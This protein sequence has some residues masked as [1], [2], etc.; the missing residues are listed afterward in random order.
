MMSCGILALQGSFAEHAALLDKC[1]AQ[2]LEVRTVSDL[3]KAD[4]LILPGGESTAIRFLMQEAGLMEAIQKRALA[5]M[6]I[7]GTCA[8]CILLAEK[9]S[10]SAPTLGLMHIAV[11]RNA[12]GAQ[13]ASFSTVASVS[14]VSPD[15]LELVFI[16][17]PVITSVGDGCGVLA[18]VNGKICAVRQ[19]KLLATTFHPELTENTAFHRYFLSL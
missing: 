9:I 13:L 15:P 3:E 10:D 17:A 11:Q 4:R 5:G 18:R 7:W 12:Y 14:A 19:N 8:G 6:P 1:G 16:R 2:P